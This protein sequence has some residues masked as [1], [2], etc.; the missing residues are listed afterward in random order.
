MADGDYVGLVD[1]DE[2]GG[3]H[4][5]EDIA[6]VLAYQDIPALE[7]CLRRREIDQR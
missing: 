5:I 2:I 3:G 6:H 4:E 7:I 1:A